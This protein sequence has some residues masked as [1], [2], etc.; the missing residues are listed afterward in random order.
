MKC[1][2]CNCCVHKWKSFN[3]YPRFHLCDR[4]GPST[5]NFFG[6]LR[7]VKIRYD[8]SENAYSAMFVTRVLYRSWRCLRYFLEKDFMHHFSLFQAP[9][10]TVLL[11]V[12]IHRFSSLIFSAFCYRVVLLLLYVIVPCRASISWWNRTFNDEPNTS[13]RVFSIWSI[14]IAI[15]DRV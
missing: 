5:C 14:T 7:R 9:F 8:R 12:Y 1:D 13:I 3:R 6:F 15:I 2:C 10:S 11:P 4:R